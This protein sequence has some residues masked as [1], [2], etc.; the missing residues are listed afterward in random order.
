MRAGLRAALPGRLLSLLVLAVVAVSGS[1]QAFA[2]G[3]GLR[4]GA[5]K[6]DARLGTEFGFNSNVQANA[7]SEGS[8]AQLNL[9]PSLNLSTPA[10][11]LMQVNAGA[12]LGWRQYL[13]V[14]EGQKDQ[15]A[16]DFGG[17]FA[18]KFNPGGAF[19][20][21]P[22]DQLR[23]SSPPNP[24]PTGEPI[25][26]VSNE[27][28][29]EF[30]Y[31]PG[32][33]ASKARLGFS[34]LARAAYGF[35]QYSNGDGYDFR[36]KG[37][38]KGRGEIRYNFLPRTAATVVAT[39]ENNVFEKSTT[40]A[41]VGD[42]S[43]EGSGVTLSNIDTTPIRIFVGGETLLSAQ[44]EV[45]AELGT[46]FVEYGALET[47]SAF[48]A[49]ARAT[50][51]LSRRNALSVE[52]LRDFADAARYAWVQYDRLSVKYA[53]NDQLFDASARLAA[54]FRNFGPDQQDPLVTETTDIVAS[55]EGRIGFKVAKGVSA[56]FRY[57]FETRS[58]SATGGVEDS[59][60]GTGDSTDIVSASDL[61]QINEFTRHQAYFTVDL[62][63]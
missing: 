40:I 9:R 60:A 12:G 26:A 61:T 10:S 49:N 33:S 56:G 38:G 58:G 44:L 2:A 19:S 11:G 28:A 35:L 50:Y 21:T 32:G 59:G 15:T 34:A 43:G 6:V 63:Y 36:D 4:V 16:P 41:D 8:V 46:A 45:G 37:I 17:I 14:P 3:Q 27:A 51:Y 20:F 7:G 30:G 53:T 23:I 24:A 39:V 52:Y 54:S 22:S 25:T 31:H 5:L 13:L 18:L 55:A 42:G 29:A 48:V 1:G 47:P 57:V 62:K